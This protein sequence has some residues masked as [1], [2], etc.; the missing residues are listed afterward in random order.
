MKHYLL[1]TPHFP[2]STFLL[3]SAATVVGFPI[4]KSEARRE[5]SRSPRSSSF[6][7]RTRR[8]PQHAHRSHRSACRARPNQNRF[9]LSGENFDCQLQS[10]R[11]PL[12]IAPRISRRSLRRPSR[13]P[14]GRRNHLSRHSRFRKIRS[15]ARKSTRTFPGRRRAR[16]S[17]EYLE[18]FSAALGLESSARSQHCISKY[19]GCR[20][21]RDRA[22]RAARTARR[23]YAFSSGS[24]FAANRFRGDRH[25]GNPI[26]IAVSCCGRH[27][28]RERSRARQTGARGH[29]H[30]PACRRHARQ[31]AGGRA[32]K[33]SKTRWPP[34]STRPSVTPSRE[35]SAFANTMSSNFMNFP[36]FV[37]NR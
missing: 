32:K 17:R 8:P 2:V 25:A 31:V 21:S 33:L 20:C 26:P 13:P 5:P 9:V 4:G 19:V 37:L 22:P 29:H 7:Y 34:I 14:T 18:R 6:S 27:A 30:R 16:I 3:R 28:N 15:S 23:R 24:P 12:P 1:P 11:L 10:S 35:S 36:N